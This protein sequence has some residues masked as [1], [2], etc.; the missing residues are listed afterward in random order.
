M[1]YFKQG[2]Y[3]A[4]GALLAISLFG[5]AVSLGYLLGRLLAG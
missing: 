2:F 5:L 3:A 4:A 1:P